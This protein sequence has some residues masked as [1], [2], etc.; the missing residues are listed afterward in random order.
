MKDTPQSR[1]DAENT[2]QIKMKL[3]KATDAD[4]LQWLNEQP[5]KQGAI[6][7]LIREAI[8]KEERD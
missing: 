8:K 3:G 5:S 6:K 4:V 2:V 1:Y 7:K